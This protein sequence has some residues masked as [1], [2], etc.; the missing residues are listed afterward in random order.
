MA[1]LCVFSEF[2]FF[3]HQ[4]VAL[5]FRAG[6]FFLVARVLRMSCMLCI[7]EKGD[8]THATVGLEKNASHLVSC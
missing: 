2:R 3:R 8:E 1:L 7:T 4:P 6:L 5:L